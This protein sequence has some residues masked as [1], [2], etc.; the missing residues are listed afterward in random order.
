MVRGEMA[1]KIGFFHS[2][3][4][5]AALLLLVFMH[6]GRVWKNKELSVL[7]GYSGKTLS[8]ALATLEGLEMVRRTTRGWQL[9]DGCEQLALWQKAE[10]FRLSAPSSS[11]SKQPMVIEGV[12]EEEKGEPPRR[13]NSAFLA[14]LD[15]SQ[16]VQWVLLTGAGIGRY[17]PKMGEILETR[18]P[19]AVVEAHCEARRILGDEG[20]PVGHLITKLLNHEAPPA[21]PDYYDCVQR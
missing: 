15:E 8:T 2:L 19:T 16:R 10:N 4:G 3:R 9:H 1:R 13:K 14:G 21:V 17:S 5:A 12:K 7:T 18:L 20:Y 6:D 11:F